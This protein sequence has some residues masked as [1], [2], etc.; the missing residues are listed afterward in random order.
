MQ[1]DDSCATCATLEG[2]TLAPRQKPDFDALCGAIDGARV[3]MRTALEARV[4]SEIVHLFVQVRHSHAE[5]KASELYFE[6]VKD[7]REAIDCIV[8]K[9]LS[10][11]VCGVVRD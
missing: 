6:E 2:I 1:H 10:A 5:A 4:K 8:R 11:V 7:T 9:G 3:T